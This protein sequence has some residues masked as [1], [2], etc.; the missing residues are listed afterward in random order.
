MFV[1]FIVALTNVLNAINTFTIGS[2]AL[3]IAFLIAKYLVPYFL[4]NDDGTMAG[5]ISIMSFLILTPLGQITQ[6]KW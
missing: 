6:K 5:I 1:N 2:M 3:Y 4:K